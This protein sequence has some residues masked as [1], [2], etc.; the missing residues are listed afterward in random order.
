MRVQSGRADPNSPREPNYCL[1]KLVRTKCPLYA[2]KRTLKLSHSA[3][4]QIPALVDHPAA[5]SRLCETI[6]PS[7]LAR[8]DQF[9]TYFFTSLFSVKP[10]NTLPSLSAVTPSGIGAPGSGAEMKLVT[11][12]SLTLPMRT[13]CRNGGFTFSFDCESA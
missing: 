9:L 11:L 8:D 7:R 3:L 2:R 6:R 5:V 10:P 13:P 1:A 4:R 12:P